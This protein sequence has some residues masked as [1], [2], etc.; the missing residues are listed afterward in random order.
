MLLLPLYTSPK[1]L[2]AAIAPT[3]STPSEHAKVPR[4]DFIALSIPYN[5][6]TDAPVPAP[7]LPCS[8]L[9]SY[10]LMHACFPISTSGLTSALPTSRSYRDACVTIGMHLSPIL[11]PTPLSSRYFITP[12]PASKPN[13]LPP[14]RTTALMNWTVFSDFSKS[15]SRVAGPPPLISTPATAPSSDMITVQPVPVA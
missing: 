6:P 7:W 13:A 3:S 14:L 11:K 9:S 15:V 5:F 12:D 8:N 2:T 1:A 4:D 10:A